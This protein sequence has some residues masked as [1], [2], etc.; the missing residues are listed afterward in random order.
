MKW[1]TK[2]CECN[3]NWLRA[4]QITPFNARDL[5]IVVFGDLTELIEKQAQ[6]IEELKQELY[7]GDYDND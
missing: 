7:I 5:I 6:E 2:W 1:I 4:R 3:W